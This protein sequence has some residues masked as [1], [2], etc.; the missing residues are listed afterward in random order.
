[1]LRHGASF[2]ADNSKSYPEPLA[3]SH[4]FYRASIHL[5]FA[6][7][8]LHA[9]CTSFLFAVGLEVQTSI[10]PFPLHLLCPLQPM[11]PKDVFVMSPPWRQP[12]S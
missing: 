1:M 8:N 7:Q 5:L 6:M 4:T 3:L 10:Y 2:A 12:I 11:M 9:Q